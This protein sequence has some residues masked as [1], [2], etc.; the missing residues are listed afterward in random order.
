MSTEMMRTVTLSCFAM[1]SLVASLAS[2]QAAGGGWTDDEQSAEGEATLDGEEAEAAP[3][4]AEAPVKAK[5]AAETKAKPAATEK[6]SADP[7]KDS[8]PKP[9]DEKNPTAHR[10]DGFYLRLS[11]GGGSVG[12]RGERYDAQQNRSDYDFRG[13]GVSFDAMVGGTPAPGIAVGG[14]YLANT[15]ARTDYEDDRTKDAGLSYGMIGPFVDIYPNPKTGFH[16]GG[17]VGPTV[18]V[19]FDDESNERSIAAGFGGAAW[20][21]Y[22]FWVSDQW[23][24]GAMFRVQGARVETPNSREL[25]E[26]SPN[27]DR[28]GLGSASLMLTALYH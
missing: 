26:D 9:E 3:A 19:T 15:A 13:N 12:A 18:A 1:V 27:H 4:E 8:P 25:D 21:G 17:A 2:A 20:I 14:A 24:L 7:K 28:L 22:D 11:L 5:P 10:H 23:S 16:I 6:S